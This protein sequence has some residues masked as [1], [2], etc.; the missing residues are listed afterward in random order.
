MGLMSV[1]FSAAL[2]IMSAVF[3]KRG[4]T[5][6]V[7]CFFFV[8]LMVC[9]FS[10]FQN[11]IYHPSE[12]TYELII[13][14]LLFFFVG[15]LAT[16]LPQIR[17]S[18]EDLEV[19]HDV[20]KDDVAFGLL[21]VLLIAYILVSLVDSLIIVR[22]F[23]EGTQLWVMRGWRMATYGVDSNPVVDRQS[24]IEVFIRAVV[25]YPFQNM[26]APL[27]AYLYFHS[28]LRRKHR[29][30]LVLAIVS[31][32][33]TV[34]A[35]GGS[36]NTIVYFV[37]CFV[38]Y[39]LLSRNKSKKTQSAR[40]PRSIWRTV[41]IIGVLAAGVF[42][43]LA[44]TNARTTLSLEANIVSY[45]GI[46]PTLL[47]LHLPQIYVSR[48]TYGLLTFFGFVTYPFRLLQQVGLDSFVPRAYTD[49]FQQM[50]NAQQ[51]ISV[52]SSELV[53]NAYVTPIYYFLIDGGT[54]FL[55]FM[56]LLFGA[57]LGQFSRAF[58]RGFTLRSF[59][60]YALIMQAILFSFIQ[61]P[62]VQP[63]FVFS[64]LYAWILLRPRRRFVRSSGLTA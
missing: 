13:I 25:L 46:S 35:T 31:L 48:H 37:A 8:W 10:V 18:A 4:L 56:S 15:S 43:I 16:F 57:V 29:T 47:S 22:N 12:Q 55:V 50:L 38:L 27:A 51:F 36:R 30:F 5:H 3:Y 7:V 62:T 53:R 33:L 23:M 63:S 40:K 45:I 41:G 34:I 54:P 64:M 17:W 26:I 20:N 42:V 24:F 9:I 19:H 60:Y 6:P 58:F 61:V 21:Y 59:V 49:A 2:L 11:T 28:E 32:V 39:Y 52:N 44:V 1:I 14:M